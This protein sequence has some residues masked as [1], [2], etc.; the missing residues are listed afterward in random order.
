MLTMSLYAFISLLYKQLLQY[1]L[2]KTFT[3]PSALL[4]EFAK[5]FQTKV[6]ASDITFT[7]LSTKTYFCFLAAV[8]HLSI[9]GYCKARAHRSYC[10]LSMFKIYCKRHYT[11]LATYCWCTTRRE[12]VKKTSPARRRH[13]VGGGGG[14]SKMSAA[15]TRRTALPMIARRCAGTRSRCKEDEGRRWRPG[16]SATWTSWS[17]YGRMLFY[18]NRRFTSFCLITT[19]M[20]KRWSLLLLATGWRVHH[21]LRPLGQPILNP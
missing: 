17:R 7:K 11:N 21:E 5:K 1:T 12:H 14:V 10:F 15:A 20:L 2:L 19:M 6:L 4:T 13:S 9:K 3:V 18:C 8:F 16:I